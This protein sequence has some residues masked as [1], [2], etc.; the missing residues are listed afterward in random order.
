M[1]LK[2]CQGWVLALYLLVSS[3]ENF[4]QTFQTQIRPDKMTRHVCLK[5]CQGWVLTLIPT[6][7]WESSGSV[8]ECLT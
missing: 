1:C 2:V 4:L 3:A 7:V 6:G 5:V 8:V